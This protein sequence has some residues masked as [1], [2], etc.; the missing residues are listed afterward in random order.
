M[1][2]SGVLAR[3]LS[4]AS[5]KKQWDVYSAFDWPAALEPGQWAMSPELMS[6]HG[7]PSWEA[8]SQ[9]Q[10]HR[11]A[12]YEV[13]NF[14]SLVLQGE[15][16]LV[17]GLVHRLYTKQSSPEVDTYLH[18]FVDEENKHMVMFGTFCRRYL[19]K[20]YPEKKVGL[21]AKLTR[22]EEEVAFFCKVLVVEEIG[23]Y[24]NV[25][26]M[27]DERL[28]PIVRALNRIHHVDESRHLAFGRQYLREL[29]GRWSPEWTPEVRAR[30]QRWLEDYLAASWADYYNPAMYAD[31]G[32]E[33]GYALHRAALGA[34]VAAEHRRRAS[35]RLV[36]LFL[37]LGLL[38]APPSLHWEG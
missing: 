16:P 9:E 25:A 13:G 28:P 14:F 22:G 8:L 2:E 12:L 31:A 20:V 23:D 37:E 3:R 10:L 29:C 19:G 27:K 26:M 6:L 24:Y 15:R 4:E 30:M 33:D 36:D 32:L 5:V 35:Q 7:T 34:P 18:H 17:Q 11:L 21:A 1:D 38:A